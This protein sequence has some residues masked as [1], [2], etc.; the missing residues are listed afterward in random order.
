MEA[1]TLFLPEQGQ[2]ALK[3]SRCPYCD[4]WLEGTQFSQE[5]ER[6]GGL[7][8]CSACKI[9]FAWIDSPFECEIR[10]EMK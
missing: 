8:E 9:Q 2:T 7:V 6:I 4:E 10:E 3:E 5:D 1:R